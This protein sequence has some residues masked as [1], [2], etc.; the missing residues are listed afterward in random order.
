MAGAGC[1]EEAGRV[2]GAGC[3][4]GAA[5][6]MRAGSAAGAARGGAPIETHNLRVVRASSPGRVL[7]GRTPAASRRGGRRA[8]SLRRR[9]DSRAYL[10]GAPGRR[11][12]GICASAAPMSSA[13][14]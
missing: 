2:A 7:T 12:A 10:P 1:A 13:A 14:K 8:G 9:L 11:A 6:M 5:R 3:A 4:A